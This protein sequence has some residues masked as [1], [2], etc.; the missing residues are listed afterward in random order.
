MKWA[1]TRND[2]L[3]FALGSFGTGVFS[4]VPAVL[5]LYFCK[6]TLKVSG[7]VAAMLILIP[8]LWSIAWDALVG[9]WSDHSRHPWGRRRPFMI[10]GTLGMVAAFVLLFNVPDLGEG[11]T[12]AWVGILAGAAGAPMIVKAVG[13][14]RI[15]YG[16]MGW[17]IAFLCLV[18]MSMPLIML[19]GRDHPAARADAGLPRNSLIADMI[20]SMTN[21]KF[22]R[23]SLAYLIQAIAF[24]A[25]SAIIAY[26]VTKGMGRIGAD[27]GTALGIYLLATIFAVRFWS[28]L[29][30]KLGSRTAVKWSAVS[31]GLGILGIGLI[32]LIQLEWSVALGLL[33]IAGIALFICVVPLA[34]C[35]ISTFFMGPEE[36]P[37]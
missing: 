22:R 19:R 35:L 9:S 4:T 2:N 31:Y 25:F 37:I 33:A 30:T 7:S 36:K 15:G 1:V 34:L 10:A 11:Q 16:L 18:A 24:G 26:L 27:I 20:A 13:G 8:K 29:G 28:W 12:V 21:R 14:G 5:L 32:V 3:S 6:E 17:T 23:L